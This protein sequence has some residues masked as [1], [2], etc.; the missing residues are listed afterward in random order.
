MSVCFWGVLHHRI[1]DPRSREV[2]QAYTR[3]CITC[4]PAFAGGLHVVHELGALVST[5]ADFD[6]VGSAQRCGAW[7]TSPAPWDSTSKGDARP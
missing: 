1:P 3:A 6:A 5:A 4:V 7:S 2:L